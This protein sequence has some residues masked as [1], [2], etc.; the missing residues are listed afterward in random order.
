MV[1]RVPRS[2]CLSSISFMTTLQTE[3]ALP[4]YAGLSDADAAAALNSGVTGGRQLVPLW[5]AQQWFMAEGLWPALKAAALTPSAAAFP[6]AS[7][8]YDMMAGG[9][10]QNVDFD[11][12]AVKPTL[13]G[14]VAAG[15]LTSDQRAALDTLANITTTRGRQLG[16]QRPISAGMVTAARAAQ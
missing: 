14:L 6:V 2:S 7:V 15:L 11:N 3:L 5:I 12:A 8:V 1:P 13:D 9:K 10:F 4:V 16:Y